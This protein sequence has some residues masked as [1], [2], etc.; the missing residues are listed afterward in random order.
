MAVVAS[1]V[2]GAAIGRP[3]LWLDEAATLSGANRPV[4]SMMELFKRLDVVHATYYLL[5]HAWGGVF[6]FSPFALRSISAVSAVVAVV[7]LYGI[8]RLAFGARVGV[9]AALALMV[10]P[11]MIWAATEGRSFALQAALVVVMSLLLLI[12]ARRNRWWVW[13]LYVVV[14]VLAVHVFVWTALVVG[15]HG[16]SVLILRRDLLLRWGVAAAVAAAASVPFAILAVA[17]S[18]QVSVVPL[19]WRIPRYVIVEQFFMKNTAVAIGFGVVLIVGI[20]ISRRPDRRES[21]RRVAAFVLP[22]LVL[23]TL[24]ILAYSYTVDPLYQPRAVVYSA[25]ALALIIG[26]VLASIDWRIATALI[27][28]LAVLAGPSWVQSRSLTAKGTDWDL[29]SAYVLTQSG[30]GT[31]VMES[32]GAG[33]SYNSWPITTAYPE[34]FDGVNDLT[35]KERHQYRN[36]LI[37]WRYLPRDK[38]LGPTFDKLDRVLVIRHATNYDPQWNDDASYELRN[39]GY[40]LVRTKHFPV[41]D[42]QVWHR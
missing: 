15:A 19:D 18:A 40:S 10:Q 21:A 1:V 20:V 42:V 5:V 31:G 30:T 23:P 22:W 16:A 3:S 34:R 17:Q 26:W 41:S 2:L 11:R 27:A 6:G 37:D 28:A 13:V 33:S 25:P 9:F 12:A 29:V 39:H 38:E 35:M 24:L 7:G 36:T 32:L 4:T 8:G 14:A